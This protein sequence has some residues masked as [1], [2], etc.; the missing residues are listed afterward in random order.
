MLRIS[1]HSTFIL[2]Y[3]GKYLKFTIF[4]PKMSIIENKSPLAG[5]L[6][7]NQEETLYDG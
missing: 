4:F 1:L 5:M 7:Q 2:E 3:F 6:L